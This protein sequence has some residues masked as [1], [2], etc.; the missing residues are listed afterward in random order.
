MILGKEVIQ[1]TIVD[2]KSFKIWKDEAFDI[3]LSEW[4]SLY[5]ENSK[6][7][8]ILND[9]YKTWFLVSAVENDYINKSI[10]ELFDG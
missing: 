8:K 2:V 9:I 1:P 10:F 4:A 7:S 6:S 3:W 5:E